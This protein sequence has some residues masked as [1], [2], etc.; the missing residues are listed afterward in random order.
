MNDFTTLEN[1]LTNPRFPIEVDLHISR[2]KQARAEALRKAHEADIKFER[3]FPTK[4]KRGPYEFLEANNLL[5]SDAL[6]LSF[7]NVVN[8]TSSYSASVR[9]FITDI[10]RLSAQQMVLFYH[11]QS[12]KTIDNPLIKV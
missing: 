2:I 4:L 8:K 11:D 9:D 1:I 12:E 5:R 10:M 7:R 6:I 3:I